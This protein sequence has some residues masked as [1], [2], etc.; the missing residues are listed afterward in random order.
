VLV[1]RWNG[2][3]RRSGTLQSLAMGIEAMAAGDLTTVLDGGRSPEGQAIA[4]AAT[5]LADGLRRVL[6]EVTQGRT[7]LGA[8]W[9]EVNELAWDMLTMSESTADR[10]SDA[11]DIASD[12]SESMQRIAAA[13]EELAATIREVASHAAMAAHVATD[14]TGQVTAA[15]STVSDL[16]RSSQ[17]IEHVVGLIQRIAKQTHLLALNATI[18][19][20]HAGVAGRGF[21]VVA[22]E[23]REL[24]GQTSAATTDV[25][26]SVEAIQVGSQTAAGVMGAVTD[27]IAKVRD[28]QSAIAAAVEQQTATTGE[29]GRTTAQAAEG[30]ATLAESVD[31][32]VSA[33][34]SSAYAGAQARTVAGALSAVEDSLAQALER[35]R[36]QPVETPEAQPRVA[37]TATIDNGVMTIEND[38]IGDGLHQIAYGQHW[39]HSDANVETGDSSSYCSIPGD[40]A[41][42]RFHGRR[43]RLYAICE[44]NHG[45]GG[46]SLDGQPEVL[47]DQYNDGRV[48]RMVWQSPPLTD[49]EHTVSV[50]VTGKR[51]ADSRYIWTTIDRFEVDV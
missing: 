50:R 10:A 16:E 7:A 8:G 27:T 33:V 28:N 24:A 32:L 51:H 34:R 12:I 18:E 41:T 43:V 19:A 30:S 49:G 35:Y 21:G 39:R 38:V 15:N 48:S 13:T 9:R 1:R 36:F 3:G 4:A 2:P 31:G 6:T 47:A 14:V 25:A 42:L 17:E 11:A 46:V 40:V 22:D 20:A 29:I 45:I 37:R 44:A 5:R 26:R 23:V